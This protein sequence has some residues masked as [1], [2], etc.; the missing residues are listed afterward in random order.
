MQYFWG[1]FCQ[2][3][4]GYLLDERKIVRFMVDTLSTTPRGI[5]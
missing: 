3:L 2:K 4:E 5:I 1:V